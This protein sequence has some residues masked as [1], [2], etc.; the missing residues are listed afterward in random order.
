[1]YRYGDPAYTLRVHLQCPFR[2]VQLNDHMKLFNSLMS[3]SRVLVEWLLEDIVNY[4]RF[5]DFKNRYQGKMYI[6]SALLQNAH[7]CV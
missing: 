3:S 1:M 4:F 5:V 2:N 6:T 7:T